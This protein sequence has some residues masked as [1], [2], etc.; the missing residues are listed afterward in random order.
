[1]VVSMD[2]YS[3]GFNGLMLFLLIKAVI[4][5][6]AA[7]SARCRGR[8]EDTEHSLYTRDV[9]YM[10]RRTDEILTERN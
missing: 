4:A 8:T 6:G 1:M 9:R 2:G 10:V 3:G 7:T 5:S